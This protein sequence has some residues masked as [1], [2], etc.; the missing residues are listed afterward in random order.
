MDFYLTRPYATGL[1]AAVWAGLVVGVA[2]FATPIKFLAPGVAMTDLLKVG[3]VTFQAFTWLELAMFVLLLALTV[4]RFTKPLITLLAGLA[5][6]L[7]V[8]KGLILP[9]L[10]AG[11]DSVVAGQQSDGSNLHIVYIV[12][13]FVKLVLLLLIPG[14]AFRPDSDVR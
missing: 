1:L 12:I 5:I 13:D 4:G 2:F 14:F 8:Q 11:L 7:L 6:L 9:A 3:K 10:D